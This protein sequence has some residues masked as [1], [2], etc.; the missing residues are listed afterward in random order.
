MSSKLKAAGR[1]EHQDIPPHPA[2]LKWKTSVAVFS[3]IMP[4]ACCVQFLEACCCTADMR[5]EWHCSH[6][7]ALEKHCPSLVLLDTTHPTALAAP[8][9]ARLCSSQTTAGFTTGRNHPPENRRLPPLILHGREASK[10][11]AVV[12]INNSYKSLHVLLIRDPSSV[13]NFLSDYEG[14][15]WSWQSK[16]AN[17][18][19][20]S[21]REHVRMRNF[22]MPK[23]V[24]LLVSLLL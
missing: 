23:C 6:R 14:A 20:G 10:A 17:E 21:I 9:G 7:V 16:T 2:L 8:Q 22:T 18:K 12:P 4:V 1:E 15:E 5:Q 13:W 11:S 24:D 3:N 19:A